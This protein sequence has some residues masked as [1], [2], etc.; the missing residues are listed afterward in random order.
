M[1][2]EREE[3]GGVRLDRW[4]W[5]ARFFKTRALAVEAIDG[6]KVQVDGNRVKRAKV[7]RTG[8]EIRIRQGPY[9]Q[10]VIVRDLS[11][12]RGPATE[13]ATLYEE[14]SASKDARE[15]IAFQLKA[16]HAAFVQDEN[17]RPTKRDRR[18]ID[19]L[20]RRD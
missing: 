12:R 3:T 14:T 18:Q 6:G 4:L 1:K 8:N 15:R 19:R 16:V 11:E 9:E 5:A 13:A 2:E 17:V 20:R 10:I 7:I